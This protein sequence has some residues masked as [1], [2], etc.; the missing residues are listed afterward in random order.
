MGL[1][2]VHLFLIEMDAVALVALRHMALRNNEGPLCFGRWLLVAI[3][4]LD[5]AFAVGLCLSR[6]AHK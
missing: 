3:V 1:I 6:R 2:Y 5:P 4:Q